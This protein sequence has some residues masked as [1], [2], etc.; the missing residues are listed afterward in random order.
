MQPKNRPP[1]PHLLT[2]HRTGTRP[3]HSVRLRSQAIRAT[4]VLAGFGLLSACAAEEEPPPPP[5]PAPSET[6]EEPTSTPEPVED[7]LTQQG[8]S[9]GHPLAVEAGEQV[10]TEGGNSVD[11]AIA[12][13]FAMSVV[14]PFASGLG[15]GG[16]VVIAGQDGDPLFYDYREMVGVDGEIPETGI[17][18]PGFVA[19]MGRLHQEH[20]SL[21]W[22]RLIQPAQQLA[23]EGFEVYDFLATR[24][25]E[26]LGPE[27]IAGV[28][29]FEVD[30]EP[31]ESGDQLVQTDLAS[32]LET[33][34]AEGW[35]S[36]YTGSLAEQ[37]TQVEGI[38]AQ[39][40]ADYEVTAAEPVSG[41]FGDY[42][43][44]AA[45]PALPGPALVQ[46][47]QIAE[48]Q[49]I[50]E[51]EPGSAEYIQTL[52]EAWLVAE[53]TVLTEI[54]DPAF[55]QVPVE[56][57]TDAE[58]NAAMEVS[59]QSAA[60]DP[61]QDPGD[62]SAQAQGDAPQAQAGAPK[63]QAPQDANTTH[64]SVV[65]DEGIMV[66][67]TN[68]LT[69]FWGAGEVSGGF[70]LNNQ[71]SR[72]EAVDSPANQPEPGRK[73]VTWSMPT[74]VLDD[75]QRPVLGIGTPGGHQIL[76]IMGTVLTQWG[77]QDAPLQ[78]A[79]DGL[80]FRLIAEDELLVL[81]DEPD[82]Q[83][84]EALE[85]LGWELQVWPDEWGG[86][87]SVQALE[88]DYETGE[89]TGADDDRRVGSHTVID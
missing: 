43:V 2:P 67:M 37:L 10:L 48:S 63:A 50:A 52:S 82:E 89:V 26:D 68:T 18:A 64:V 55:V 53:E 7:T 76:N 70:F 83:T 60:Q 25:T 17:G 16:S 40:L 79:V 87:G 31:L 12:A 11:A 27:A 39:T 85:D 77:L 3:A 71:L 24:M 34:A 21:D 80:R 9:A 8:V 15:G 54:G 28:E 49:G 44:L 13:A 86:F 19:G 74:I 4:A 56:E 81:D 88:V 32:T 6:P 65:D 35:E 20:G 41:E 38:D 51:L 46:L 36:F 75:Q 5:P 61:D 58:S 84:R 57:I 22:D 33:L 62:D 23:S 66:S 30:G 69:N 42:Q 1:R 59:T 73:S 78:E 45:A 14:E 72:F 47:L 29:P